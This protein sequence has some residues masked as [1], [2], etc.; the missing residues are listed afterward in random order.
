MRPKAAWHT[1]EALRR[2][3]VLVRSGQGLGPIYDIITPRR[4]G[5]RKKQPV[6]ATIISRTPCQ[7]PSPPTAT[8]REPLAD[9]P[10]SPRHPFDPCPF[11]PGS[12]PL[13]PPSE[14]LRTGCPEVAELVAQESVSSWNTRLP[15]SL[16]LREGG[17]LRGWGGGIL[18]RLPATVSPFRC[19]CLLVQRG[20]VRVT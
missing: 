9:P 19:R 16:A 8:P 18:S 15:E 4:H 10:R 7:A 13:G 20:R 17:T 11:L 6:P 12:S 5:K 2:S 14:S 3:D 1:S